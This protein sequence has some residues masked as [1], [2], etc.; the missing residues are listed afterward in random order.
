[1]QNKA[2]FGND[3]MNITLDM[4]SIYRILFRSP[5]KKTNPKQTQLKPKQTQ[6]KPNQSQNKANQ[7]QF[8][9]PKYREIDAGFL[10]SRNIQ[11]FMV[12]HG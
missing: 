11:L 7:S 6:F 9:Q 10:L 4:T 2:N 3:N 5:G 8:L 12:N 1:M